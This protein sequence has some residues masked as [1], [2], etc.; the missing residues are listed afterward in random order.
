MDAGFE[1]KPFAC[2]QISGRSVQPSLHHGAS[3]RL[4]QSVNTLLTC[5]A[6]SG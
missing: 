5:F 3:P 1:S 6:C 4:M 2:L